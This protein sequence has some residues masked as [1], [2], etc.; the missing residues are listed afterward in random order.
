M[1]DQIHKPLLGALSEFG[2]GVLPKGTRLFHGSRAESPHTNAKGR[3]LSGTRKWLSQS[4]EYAVSYAFVHQGDFGDRLLWV[5][6]LMA[7]VPAFVGSQSALVRM[8]PWGASFPWKFPDSFVDYAQHLIPGGGPRALLD[9]R[10][11]F[12]YGEVLLTEPSA[13]LAVVDLRALPED[14]REAE[15]LA[16]DLFG[17]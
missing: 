3:L 9:H 2:Q 16:L 7:D 14:K 5:C 1:K 15:R 10:R 13:A 12:G 17:C 11:E 8:S 4:A 6:E